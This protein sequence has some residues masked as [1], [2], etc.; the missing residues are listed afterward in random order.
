M[1][2]CSDIRFSDL[3]MDLDPNLPI[4]NLMVPINPFQYRFSA[5]ITIQFGKRH[6]DYIHPKDSQ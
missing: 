4:Q 5:G 2:K 3:G 1:G 6:A